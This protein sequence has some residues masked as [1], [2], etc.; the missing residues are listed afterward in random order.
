M[1]D[2]AGIQHVEITFVG[3][4]P[5]RQ[6]ERAS[7]VTDVEVDGRTVRCTV[8]GSF[9]PFLEAIRGYEVISLTATPAIG[10]ADRG[11]LTPGERTGD[12]NGPGANREPDADPPREEETT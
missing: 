7:G 3:T 6:I 11:D 12:R 8:R 2:G 1:F 9:Q 4:A 5:S 10:A